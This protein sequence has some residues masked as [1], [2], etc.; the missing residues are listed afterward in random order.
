MT[1][2]VLQFY[3]NNFPDLDSHE[4]K[5][6]WEVNSLEEFKFFCCSEC[7]YRSKE[8]SWYENHINEQHPQSL[9]FLDD[10]DSYEIKNEPDDFETKRENVNYEQGNRG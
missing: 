7:T 1:V 3:F 8:N 5:S 6:P 4:S 9:T 2:T 10:S